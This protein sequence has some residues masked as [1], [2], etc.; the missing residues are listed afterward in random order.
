MKLG[1][2]RYRDDD[3]KAVLAAFRSNVPAHFPA[4]EETWLRSALDDPDG[5]VRADTIA[6]AQ[7]WFVEHGYVP[8]KVDLSKVI[9]N[10]FAD[11]AV[12]QLGPY[13]P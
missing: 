4:S 5:R 6:A 1:I 7:D 2:R 12:Q 11:Y 13:Q 9:D 3:R 8:T 10:Q